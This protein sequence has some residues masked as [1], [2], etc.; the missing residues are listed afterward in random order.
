MRAHRRRGRCAPARSA[1]RPRSRR[2]TSATPAARCRAAPPTLEE[3]EALAGCLAEVA[4]GVMQATLGPGLFLDE[5]AAIQRAHRQAGQLDGAARRHARPRRAPLRPR[6]LGG[7]AGATASRVVPQVVLPAAQLRVP[8][9]GAVPVREHVALQAGLARPT[10]RARSAS[11][12]TRRSARRSAS[13]WTTGACS[14]AGSHDMVISEYAPEPRARGA[15]RSATSPPSAACTRRPRARP[16]RSR[17]TSRR[18]SASPSSTP[19]RRPSPSCSRIRRRCS[20]SPTPARTRASSATPARRPTCSATGCARRACSSLEEAV[21]R[22][23][24]QPAEVFGIRDRGRL[25][26]GLAADVTVFDP[27]TVGCAPLRRVR[28]FP[29]G[30]D[31]LVADA[32]GIRAVV[33]NGAVIREDGPRRASTADGAAARPRAA[34]RTRRMNAYPIISAD[35]H[36]TEPP[37]TYLDYIDAAVPRPRAAHRAHR[38]R[39]DV[40]VD[41]RHEDAGAAGHRRRGGQAGRGDPH[42]RAR[43]SRSCTA[44]AGIPTRASPTRSATASPPRSSTRRSAW[45]SATTSDFDYKKACFDAYNRWIAEYCA[46]AS[47][48]ACSASGRRRCAR[49]RK[50]SR[51]LA[52]RSRRSA[53]AA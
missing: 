4:H 50:A 2:R 17:P 25:A 37:N 30:A 14:P 36:I 27:R 31:R 33:V 19:T 41:R 40:F 47:R 1:S 28:D 46:R 16:R 11:T 15:A 23:T 34:R 35:S 18:A 32:H 9:Q 26:A 45:C 5:F 52:A 38:R 48:R 29:A 22:L 42:H 44:A 49:P 51:D 20:A 43:A 53:C 6:A 21:R 10:S 39:G 24:S 3:I 7:A 13:A 12:P 8:V